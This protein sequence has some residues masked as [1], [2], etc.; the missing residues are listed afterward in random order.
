MLVYIKS[1]HGKLI[2][3]DFVRF[4]IV[5]ASGFFI[6]LGL[7][8]VLYGQLGAPLFVAQLISAEVALFSNFI[9]HH[10]WT[11]KSKNVTKSVPN[12]LT[13]FHA[14][15]W[16]A[17]VGS[18]VMVTVGVRYLELNYFVALV[19]SSAVALAW[20]FF[21]TKFVIW[22]HHHDEVKEAKA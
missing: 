19:I 15:S 1:V 5:G 17:I 2:K 14:T 21:W 22:R 20:N 8:T 16:A 12:L 18:A 10:N 3:I 6:N 9:L 11:Y 7:L 4:C 13:Q